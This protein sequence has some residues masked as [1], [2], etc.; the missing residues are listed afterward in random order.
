MT[1]TVL[2]QRIPSHFD[3]PG[4]KRADQLAKLGAAMQQ[5]SIKTPLQTI[6]KYFKAHSMPKPREKSTTNGKNKCWPVK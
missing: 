6:K 3:L 2:L 1:N 5:P 4:N